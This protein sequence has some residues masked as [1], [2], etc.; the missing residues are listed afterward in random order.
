MSIKPKNVREILSK[1]IL[2]DGFDPI[3]D[4][5]KSHGSW[6]VDQRDGSEYL[7]MFSM[8]AS[9]AVGYNHPY[10]VK[11]QDVLGKISINKTTLSD[12]YNI[13]YAD[14]IETFNKY[15]APNYLK[16]AFFIDGGALAV[17]NALKTAF[18]WKKRLNLKKGI[19]KEGDK[20]IY[21]NQ[22]FHGRSGYTMTLTNTSDPR[23]TMYYPKFDW[24]KVDNPHLSFPLNDDLLEDVIKK[25]NLVI[26]NIKNILNKNKDDVAAIIIEP[27]QGEG[28][29]N[30]FRNEFMILL[31]ELCDSNEMLLIF[32]E[33]QTGVGITGKMWAHEHFSVK[34]DVISFGKKTQVCGMLAGDKVFSMDKNVFKE[35]SRINSTFGGNLVDMYRFKLILEIMC[36]E[37]LL[38]NAKEM[39]WYLLSKINDLSLEFPGF[40]TNPRGV[41][42]FCAFDLPSTIERDKFISLVFNEKL[43]I[44]GSGDSSIRFRP[45]LNV[46]KN[47]IDVAIDII[48]QTL[49]KML[50]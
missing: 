50:N 3:I 29:D 16:H 49:K 6:I 12:I 26:E 9:G 15:A 40:A 13:Y 24:F 2:A 8:Y 34:P 19:N 36:N 43:M 23:K 14:F 35:S 18:D 5:D 41:G 31:K 48:S 21:F 10:I 4:L 44:L 22:A 25:E 42:L 33:V 39:G 20:I 37:N 32:D 46:S 1:N 27:I 47:D 17:E 38:S 28:G 45:H 7:D 11:N 30:H